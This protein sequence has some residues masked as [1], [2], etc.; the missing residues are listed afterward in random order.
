MKNSKALKKA[1]AALDAAC[2]KNH[3]S[4]NMGGACCQNCEMGLPCNDCGEDNACPMCGMDPCACDICSDC[5][6]DPCVCDTCP[7]CGESP[8]A[9]GMADNAEMDEVDTPYEYLDELKDRYREAEALAAAADMSLE[10]WLDKQA[11]LYQMEGAGAGVRYIDTIDDNREA[12]EEQE[13]ELSAAVK[14]IDK[15]GSAVRM[16]DS[17]D[18]AL[19]LVM[20]FVAKARAATKAGRYEAAQEALEK[21]VGFAE[22]ILQEDMFREEAQIREGTAREGYRRMYAKTVKA[23]SERNA[24]V[25]ALKHINSA[26]QEIEDA[27][28]MG[29]FQYQEY[30]DTL[31]NLYKKMR[32]YL[33]TMAAVSAGSDLSLWKAAEADEAL[34][35]AYLALHRMKADM[36][37]FEEIPPYLQRFYKEVMDAASAIGKARDRTNTVREMAKR[38]DRQGRN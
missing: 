20:Q 17:P 29:G 21:A 18:E 25:K 9:C 6:M 15:A 34:G 11:A 27:E 26:I 1:L 28:G 35:Q 14:A 24:W 10:D 22:V 32:Y 30:K 5:G 31:A 37:R 3:D 2:G 23:G 36:D 38:I 33:P 19:G 13:D 8:C 16:P 7:V 12:L 4:D